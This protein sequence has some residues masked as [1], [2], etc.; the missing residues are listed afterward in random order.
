MQP[1]VVAFPEL[2]AWLLVLIG[3]AL[4]GLV[5]YMGKQALRRLDLQDEALEAIRELLAS[6]VQKLREMQHAIDLRVTKIETAC[7]WL[8]QGRD[9]RDGRDSVR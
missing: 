3:T 6:E 9:G 5:L 1:V 2:A 8:H 4:L 7:A